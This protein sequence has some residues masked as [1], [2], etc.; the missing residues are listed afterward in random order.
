[1]G[2]IKNWTNGFVPIKWEAVL[3]ASSLKTDN[4]LTVTCISKKKTKNSAE[5]AIANFLATDEDK[6]PLIILFDLVKIQR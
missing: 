3:K 5:S 4:R 1:M 2:C 6:N